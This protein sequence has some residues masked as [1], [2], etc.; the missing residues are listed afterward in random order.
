MMHTDLGKTLPQ[1]IDKSIHQN[2]ERDL[3]EEDLTGVE[4]DDD[5]TVNEETGEDVDNKGETEIEPKIISKDTESQVKKKGP[6]AVKK[7][8][9]FI[10]GFYLGGCVQPTPLDATTCIK[11][12]Y[13]DPSSLVFRRESAK[14]SER[15]RILQ[16]QLDNLKETI[17]SL[18]YNAD[19]KVKI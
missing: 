5:A 4:D 1:H 8:V 13:V 19:K 16:S 18:K 9:Q 14:L 10:F 7:R 2:M 3:D 11:T 15:K 12:S 6:T 17:Q